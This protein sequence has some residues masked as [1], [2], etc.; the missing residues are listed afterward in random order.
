[1][2]PKLPKSKTILSYTK[3]NDN[4][5]RLFKIADTYFVASSPQQLYLKTDTNIDA[6]SAQLF[7]GVVIEKTN[8]SVYVQGTGK[9]FYDNGNEFAAEIIIVIEDHARVMWT[10]VGHLTPKN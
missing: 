1:M 4:Y 2:P 7:G 5:A 9:V 3:Y 10:K 8:N 6:I